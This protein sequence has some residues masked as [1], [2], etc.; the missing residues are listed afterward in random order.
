MSATPTTPPGLGARLARNSLH[1]AS[2]RVVAMLAWLVLT[3]PLVRALGP[4]GF[5]IWALFY[6]L[7]GWLGALDLGFSQVALRYGAAARAREA[8]EEAGEYATLAALGYVLLGVLW[9]M[10]A[11][12]ARDVVLDVLRIPDTVRSL[13]ARA[14][15]AG[16]IV[17]VVAGLANTTAAALQAWDRFDLANLVSLTTSLAQV[18]GLSWALVADAGLVACLVAVAAGWA[19]AFVL[20]LV[21]L[22]RGV[23]AFRWGSLASARGRL[24][25]ALRF[26]LPIQASNA[27]AVAHQMLGK[28]LLVRLVA[29]AAVVPY[30]LGLRVTTACFTFAQ[31]SLVA[32]LPEASALHA[33]DEPERLEALHRRA[34]RF[35]TAI[36]AVMAAVLFGSADPLFAAWLG[37][38]DA[39]AALALRGLAL[40]AY[41]AVVGGIVGAIGR[42]VGRIGFEL[43]WSALALATHAALGLALIPR[44]GLLGAL[45][46]IA[47]ANLVSSVWFVARLGSALRW[48]LGRLLWEPF[49]VPVVALA[50]GAWAG[51]RCSA[52]FPSAWA[53]LALSGAIAGG[54]ALVTLFALRYVSWREL[55]SLL[56]R[57]ATA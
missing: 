12:L 57:G 21:L 56:R 43:E 24:R 39:T 53:S 31:L 50:L 42:G 16:A 28:L 2:G 19:L 36:A 33:R 18:A 37:H 25:E 20:G 38:P 5:G 44:F 49:L 30:E 26:G 52:A 32:M 48:S 22:A 54:V 55:A 29:L 8:G 47:V 34:G 4:E 1:S 6:A 15:V 17:F 7:T 41:A 13:A 35:V 23:P 45:V 46:A 9:L 10:V 40:A 3:P 51:A 11:L 14:I 27:L